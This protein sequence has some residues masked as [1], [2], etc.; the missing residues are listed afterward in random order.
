MGNFKDLG[1]N[2]ELLKAVEE[3]GFLSPTAVQEQAIPYLLERKKDLIALAQTGTG[4]TAALDFLVFN[5]L[6]LKLKMC[7]QLFFAQLENYVFK[8]RRI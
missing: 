6:I 4:K 7:K 5:M 3:M 8:F 1:V 2:K